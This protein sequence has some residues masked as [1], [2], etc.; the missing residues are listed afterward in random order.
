MSKSKEI[1]EIYPD[2]ISVTESFKTK[3]FTCTKCNGTKGDIDAFDKGKFLKC[4][5]CNGTGQVEGIVSIKW[6]PKYTN[7]EKTK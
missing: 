3:V 4:N 7:H 1:I 5:F 6:N 2:S